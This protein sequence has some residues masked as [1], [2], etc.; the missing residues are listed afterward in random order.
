M[1]AAEPDASSLAAEAR[2]LFGSAPA[3]PDAS[4]QKPLTLAERLQSGF[5]T[6]REAASNIQPLDELRNAASKAKA[7]A[8]SDALRGAAD[9]LADKAKA[10]AQ[11]AKAKASVAADRVEAAAT[12]VAG[13]LSKAG[14][15][16]RDGVSDGV[17]RV[18]ALTQE[19]LLAFFMLAFAAAIMLALAFFVGLPAAPLAPSKFAIPFTLGSLFNLGALAALRGV[20]GQFRHM[21]ASERLPISATYVG[22]ML[23]T[24]YATFVLHSYVLCVAASLVQLTALL[25]YT[26]SYF[27][28]GMAGA[29]LISMS[30]GR[31]LRHGAS[32]C[33]GCVQEAK[34]TR[35][36]QDMLPI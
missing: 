34:E 12:G 8:T 18:Q 15:A 27:P 11:A 19:R 20:N 23:L 35:S 31:V 36:L 1:S 7:A 13:G 28:G 14:V 33:W 9:T 16:L 22:S 2:A 10:A 21:A 6:L 29:R 4:A 30:S 24:L 32:L 17:A 25:Y 3:A 5:S 26:L